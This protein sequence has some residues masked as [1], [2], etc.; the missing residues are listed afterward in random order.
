MATIR[1]TKQELRKRSRKI[2]FFVTDCD[3]VLTDAGIYYSALGEEMRR[4]SV[5]DGM[6]VEL[7]RGAGIETGIISGENSGIIR[8]RAHKLGITSC[9]LGTG[10]KTDALKDLMRTRNLHHTEI[11]YI[12]DDM[13]DLH[14]MEEVAGKGITACP[15]DAEQTIIDRAHYRARRKGGDGAF[16]DIVN[17]FMEIRGISFDMDPPSIGKKE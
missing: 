5:R 3:G 12:G 6:G 7:L 10:R 17:W 13:N 4:F 15:S 1:I 2:K 9:Y 16:R 14:I 8:R 11:L